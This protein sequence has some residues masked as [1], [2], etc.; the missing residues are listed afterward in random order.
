M[1]LRLL[2]PIEVV[3]DDGRV[4]AVRGG[5][6]RAM[7]MLLANNFGSL[8]TVDQMTK[9]IWGDRAPVHS[10]RVL[11]RNMLWL[12][13]TLDGPVFQVIAFPAGYTL[14]GDARHVDL[15]WFRALIAQSEQAGT[16]ADAA[17]ALGEA[18][19]LWRGTPM[20]GFPD[21]VPIR[22]LSESLHRAHAETVEAWAE[23]LLK[24]GEG[25]AAVPALEE[26][27]RADD[28]RESA[29]ALLIRCLHEAGRR[30]DAMRVYH[31]VRGSLREELGTVPSTQLQA[32]FLTALEGRRAGQAH[33]PD[34]PPRKFAVRTAELRWLD[35]HCGSSRYESNLAVVSGPAG[36]GKTA[37]V[38][39][40]GHR[41]RHLFPDGML[42]ADLRGYEPDQPQGRVLDAF[43]QTLGPSSMSLSSV[44]AFREATRDKRLLVIVDNARDEQSV[45][46]LIPHGS[47]SAAIVI[48]RNLLPG[49]VV[50]EGAS[51][52]RVQPLS[53]PDSRRL[54]ANLLPPVAMSQAIAITKLIALCEGLPLAL[55]SAARL[56]TGPHRRNL[57]ELVADLEVEESRLRHL[58]VSGLAGLR[59]ALYGTYRHLPPKAAE[60]LRAMARHPAG[61]LTA[62]QGAVLLD[63]SPVTAHSALRALATNHLAV[64]PKPGSYELPSLVRIF[65]REL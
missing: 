30:T 49:L 42:F 25:R 52:L 21:T 26:L 45:L 18:L 56:V 59:D 55:A 61:R 58:E 37:T 12:S 11:R 29:A 46:D 34:L 41:N 8:V 53:P 39:H 51:L 40:W 1:H 31:D 3:A 15:C 6:R 16:P 47:G 4:T 17:D 60:L 23:L 7:L 35:E 33:A 57:A 48:S 32:A 43:L 5:V 27:L 38:L 44:D 54:L 65:A 22:A 19:R 10:Q 20:E 62:A 24:L 64:E 9:T 28:T 14:T 13:E 36:V 63:D 2:G 50:A